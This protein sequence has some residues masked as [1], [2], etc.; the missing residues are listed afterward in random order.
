MVVRTAGI[1]TPPLLH[2]ALGSHVDSVEFFLSD[3]PHR[4]YNEYAKTKQA[5]ED[6]R[7]QHIMASP[8]GFDR[9]VSKWLGGDS[10]SCFPFF[11]FF[12]VRMSRANAVLL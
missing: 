5:R 9:V 6:S 8:G 1:R 7:L 2:A 11:C 10:T 3:A 12:T 4:L